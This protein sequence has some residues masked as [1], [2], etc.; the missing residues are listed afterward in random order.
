MKRYY[1]CVMVILLFFFLLLFLGKQFPANEYGIH[2]H[3]GAPGIAV[4]NVFL[5]E[6]K[7]VVAIELDREPGEIVAYWQVDGKNS[8]KGI[9]VTD[10]G[11]WCYMFVSEVPTYEKSLQFFFGCLGKPTNY[12]NVRYV[13]KKGGT[14]CLAEDDTLPEGE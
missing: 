8:E 11:A 6:E 12:P 2:P 7:L 3:I 1:L 14:F 9:K 5:K 4:Y 13:E 10:L